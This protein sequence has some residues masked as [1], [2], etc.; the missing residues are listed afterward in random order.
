MKGIS[1][2]SNG[3]KYTGKFSELEMLALYELLEG[4]SELEDQMLEVALKKV[5]AKVK[6]WL[7]ARGYVERD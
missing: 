5:D 4:R 6:A 7:R 1:G 2:T 3:D